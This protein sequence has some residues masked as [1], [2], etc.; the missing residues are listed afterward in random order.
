MTSLTV[1]EII[2]ARGGYRVVAAGLS[3]PD[4][5]FPITTV[6]SWFRKNRMPEWREE[7]VLALPIIDPRFR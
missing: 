2:T 7:K 3:T 1:K 5:Q 6:H 4:R